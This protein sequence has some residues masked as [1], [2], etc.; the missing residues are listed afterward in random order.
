MIP[1][2]KA[3]GIRGEGLGPSDR[4]KRTGKRF[5]RS[6]GF[7]RSEYLRSSC[8][9]PSNIFAVP[10]QL[11]ADLIALRTMTE[12]RT[13]NRSKV[14]TVSEERTR[15][16]RIDGGKELAEDIPDDEENGWSSAPGHV[17]EC[18]SA[19]VNR[20]QQVGLPAGI[21]QETAYPPPGSMGDAVFRGPHS[22]ER[23]RQN[24]HCARPMASEPARCPIS[25]RARCSRVRAVSRLIPRM[26]AIS[27]RVCP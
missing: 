4:R 9:P 17:G 13:A 21:L 6:S 5:R 24:C 20:A 23:I 14:V 26:A 25:R 22:P 3:L 12:I 7:S 19:L 11:P 27:C 18:E 1:T 10:P 2:W 16:A 15:T 8:L